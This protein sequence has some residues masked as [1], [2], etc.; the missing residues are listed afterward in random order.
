MKSEKEILEQEDE[1][2]LCGCS[3]EGSN[4]ISFAGDATQTAVSDIS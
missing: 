4:E 2:D 1:R 3:V